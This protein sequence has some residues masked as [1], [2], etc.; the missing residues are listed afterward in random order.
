[1]KLAELAA[2]AEEKYQ[3]KEQHKWADF[4]GFSVL[5]VP[6]TGKWAALLMR[7]KD[8]LTGAEVERCDIK[9]GEQNLSDFP[10]ARLSGP[11]RMK[12]SKWVGVTFDETTDPK[13]VCRLFD[14]AV[15]FGGQQGFTIILEPQPVR[16]GSVYQDT[17]LPFGERRP[18]EPE[19]ELPDRIRQMIS[20]YEYGSGSFQQKCRNFYRQ[21]MFMKDYGDDQPWSGSFFH[22]FPTYHDLNDKQLRGYFTWRTNVRK[23]RF[24]P[25]PVSAAYIY[26]YELLNGVGADSLQDSL[27]KLDAFEKGFL[28]SGLGDEQMRKNLRRWKFEFA[29]VN[30]FPAETVRQFAEPEML[31]KDAALLCLKDPEACFEEE[32]FDALCYFS[33]SSLADSPVIRKFEERGRHLFCEAWKTAA[34]DS[35]AK[36]ED[37]FTSCFG[38]LCAFA[39]Y[40]LANAVY[41]QPNKGKTRDYV[42]NDCRAFRCTAGSWQMLTHESLYFNKN[43]FRAFCHETDLKLRRYLKTGRYLREKP[44]D[45]W[46]AVYVDKVVEAEKKAIIEA[47][48]PR[49]E[50]DLSGLDRIR[51]EAVVTRDSLLTEEDR[52]E[53]EEENLSPEPAAGPVVPAPSGPESALDAIQMQILRALLLEDSAD[54]VLKANHLMPSVAADAINEALFDEFGDTVLSC[55]DDKLVIVEDYREDLLDLLENSRQELSPLTQK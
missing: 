6:A 36:G 5:S 48:K 11:F 12:G 14:R 34:A 40:P 46:A 27:A 17:P 1:M 45:E 54:A 35:R 7:L 13:M 37:F 51:E 22:Y 30:D 55:D 18:P 39:W 8:P 44:E 50:I 47:S 53:L 15:N 26:V 29:V 23:G 31:K 24:Q 21:G 43:L 2:Y 20:M 4:P 49:I 25:I 16:T 10:G 19:A 28:D 9:C 42:L 52:I 32:L 33:G 3:I 38:E 41:W